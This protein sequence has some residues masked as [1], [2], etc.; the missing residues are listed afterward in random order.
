MA[1]QNGRLER[2]REK[3]ILCIYLNPL[4]P[5]LDTATN[6]PSAAVQGIFKVPFFSS[7]VVGCDFSS[8]SRIF[9]SAFHAGT[10][11]LAILE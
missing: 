11:P 9:H 5:R 8:P 10:S 6:R 4:M 7:F 2:E 1:T 3:V